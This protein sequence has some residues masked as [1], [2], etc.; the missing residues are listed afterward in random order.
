M[1]PH[2]FHAIF[3]VVFG[4]TSCLLNLSIL[5][6]LPTLATLV[7]EFTRVFSLIKSKFPGRMRLIV[8]KVNIMG[9][10]HSLGVTYALKLS[11]I[12]S[13]KLTLTI[14]AD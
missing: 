1:L 10:A 12:E 5:L 9:V 7:R 8:T 13:T 4:I 11:I 14:L 3:Y 2:C 6:G